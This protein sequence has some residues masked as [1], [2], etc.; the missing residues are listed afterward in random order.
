MASNVAVW[1]GGFEVAALNKGNWHSL[2]TGL[3]APVT[4]LAANSLNRVYASIADQVERVSLHL[5]SP[6]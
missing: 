4:S 2:G 6:K 3:T 1:N 5:F